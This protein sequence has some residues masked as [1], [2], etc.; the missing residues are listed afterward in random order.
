MIFR[1]TLPLIFLIILF[2]LNAVAAPN[3]A[4]SIRPIHSIVSNLTA[5]LGAPDLLLS[6]NQSAHHSH[7]KPSQLTALTRADL[8][9]VIHP[10]FEAGL[11]KP[12]QNLAPE[13]VF[14]I[15]PKLRNHHS[16]LSVNWSENFAQNLT[17]KLIEIDPDNQII[18]RKNLRV[19]S[20]KLR[21]LAAQITHK[22]SK[23]SSKTVASFAPT[24]TDFIRENAL[25][26]SL[27]ITQQHGQ[28]LSIF[29]VLRARE[30]LKTTQTPCLLATTEVPLKRLKM[31]TENLKIRTASIDIIGANLALGRDLYFKLMQN[32]AQKVGQC[33]G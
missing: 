17:K 24:F 25:K 26:S 18:Y 10:D 22:L 8:V 1:P 32:I 13:K 29:N 20:Q 9:V 6:A 19:F 2:S 21:T 14:I 27:T 30:I 7:L 11:A 3:I 15:N 31:L 33:L 16:W 5:G 23:T 28:R 4:V 12:V